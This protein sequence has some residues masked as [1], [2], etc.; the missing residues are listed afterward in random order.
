MRSPEAL[1]YHID[2]VERA[3]RHARGR[4]DAQ[5]VYRLEA[6]LEALLWVTGKEVNG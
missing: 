3:L 2:L 6:Q 4:H 1:A 5:E